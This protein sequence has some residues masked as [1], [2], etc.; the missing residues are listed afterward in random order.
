MKIN[1]VVQRIAT[2]GQPDQRDV[3]T[4]CVIGIGMPER[5]TYE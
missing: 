3:E 1:I 2:N 5:N 4:G